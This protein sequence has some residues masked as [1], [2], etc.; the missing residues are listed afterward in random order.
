MSAQLSHLIVGGTGFIGRSLLHRW[1]A[2]ARGGVGVLLR[3]PAPSWLRDLGFAVVEGGLDALPAQA[4]RLG[5]D[6]VVINL[7]RPDGNGDFATL[8]RRLVALAAER[9]CR[10]YV[11]ASSIEVYAG[12][13]DRR[14]DEQAVPAPVTPYQRE[15]VAAEEAARRGLGPHPLVILCLGAVFGAGGAN[16][17]MLAEDAM[18]GV[19]WRLALQRILHG[20]RRMYLVPVE[21]VAEAIRF[22]ADASRQPS[23]PRLLLAE[24]HLPEN[25]FATV[26]GTMLAAFGR[27]DMATLPALPPIML[28]MA[29]R[30]RHGYA[31]DPMRRFEARGLDDMGFRRS[32]ELHEG[33][34]AF[35]ASLRVQA[36][37]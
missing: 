29:L 23:A 25:D 20:R 34:L 15:H 36:R 14:I 30:L 9:R 27:G 18:H 16:A 32:V 11:H 19:L 8:T 22:L 17:K 5:R 21:T 33:L 3:R 35:A 37:T 10:R 24:D 1:P 7:A 12:S 13:R 4:D 31:P 2:T 6:C 26:L 28:E